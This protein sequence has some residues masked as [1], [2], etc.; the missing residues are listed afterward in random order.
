MKLKILILLSFIF[1]CGVGVYSQ[2]DS[3]KRT[4]TDPISTVVGYFT[5]DGNVVK[6]FSNGKVEFNGKAKGVYSILGGET[7]KVK[8]D[9]DAWFVYLIF[10]NNVY[11]VGAG[12]AGVITDFDFDP[13]DSYITIT[14]I[15]GGNV[16]EDDLE[17]I[18]LSSP[19]L[20]ITDLFIVSKVDWD[21]TSSGQ[22]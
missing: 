12:S 5:L 18:D 17:S 2:N 9:D 16:T 13:S 14:E 15:D 6:L 8:I 22:T 10:E 1:C 20:P 21:K 3:S 4:A 7:Y 11:E 19:E